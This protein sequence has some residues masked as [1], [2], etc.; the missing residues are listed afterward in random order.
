MPSNR[1]VVY[2]KPGM[3]EVQKIDFPTFRNPTGK[4][5]DHGVIPEGH[6]DEHLRL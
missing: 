4:P 5:I 3:V 2:L 1:G 6:D